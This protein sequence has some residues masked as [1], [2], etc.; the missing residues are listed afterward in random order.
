MN[1]SKA[2]ENNCLC[3]QCELR[4]QCFTQE[5]IFSD[6]LQQGL[7]EAMI[8]EGMNKEAAVSAVKEEIK[9]RMEQKPWISDSGDSTTITYPNIST[10]DPNYTTWTTCDSSNISN[11]NYTC[12]N[13]KEYNFN[14][15]EKCFR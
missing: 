7:F 6:S 1:K 9:F 15:H 14:V 5:R 8:A 12:G 4:Y 3:E 10:Y 2:G 11:I 13:G